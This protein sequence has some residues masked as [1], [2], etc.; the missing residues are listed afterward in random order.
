MVSQILVYYNN[1]HMVG[2]ILV[3]YID[4][5]SQILVYYIIYMVCQILVL[6]YTHDRLNSSSL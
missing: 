6:L 3:H 4:M 5:V 1:I 2:Q